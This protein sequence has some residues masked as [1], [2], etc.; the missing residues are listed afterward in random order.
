MPGE[1]GC[2]VA[3]IENIEGIPLFLIPKAIADQIKKKREAVFLITVE[4]RFHHRYTVVV[5]TRDEYVQR[6][7]QEGAARV[8]GDGHG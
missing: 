3:A 5:E 8:E 2:P 6:V 7:K 4:K 1:A